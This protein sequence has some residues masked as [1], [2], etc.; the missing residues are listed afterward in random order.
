MN[1]TNWREDYLA[2]KPGL[3]PLQIELLKNGPKSLSSSWMLGA[4]YSDWK[5]N[6]AGIVDP[7]APDCS[8]SLQEWEARVKKYQ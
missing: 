7:P 4:M 1:D 8:S 2:R 3:K 5:K 6:I